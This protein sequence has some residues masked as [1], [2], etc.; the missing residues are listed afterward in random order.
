MKSYNP[1]QGRESSRNRAL[2]IIVIGVAGVWVSAARSS[3]I[4]SSPCLHDGAR[5]LASAT[6]QQIRTRCSPD[7][8][9]FER[10]TI[11]KKS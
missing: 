10:S 6:A 2:L 7:E 8:K 4:R 11:S 1:P 5:H 9:K 3:K